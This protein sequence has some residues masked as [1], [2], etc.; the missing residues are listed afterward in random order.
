MEDYEFAYTKIASTNQRGV[1]VVLVN[2][3][4]LRFVLL[5]AKLESGD[6][7]KTIPLEVLPNETVKFACISNLFLTGVV[8]RAL[9]ASP[10]R[11]RSFRLTWSNPYSFFSSS[12]VLATAGA[13]GL[14]VSF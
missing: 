1:K 11:D 6:W 14:E 3:T 8:G 2:S 13:G 10:G 4:S 12:E 5:D 7:A 9:F